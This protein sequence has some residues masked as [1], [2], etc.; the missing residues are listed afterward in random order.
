VTKALKEAIAF[1][2]TTSAG[3][4]TIGAARSRCRGPGG[5]RPLSVVVTSIQFRDRR[6]PPQRGVAAVFVTVADAPLTVCE[7]QLRDI[8]DL[9]A[10]E[11]RVVA[12]LARGDS[13]EQASSMLGI[14]IE[15]ARTHLKRIFSKKVRSRQRELVHLLLAGSSRVGI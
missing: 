7:T 9:T 8:H 11:A 3:E 6:R 12:S 15:T 2:A 13:L 10:A 14:S 4:G 1:A 5:L